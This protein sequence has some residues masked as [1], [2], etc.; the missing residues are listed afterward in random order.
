MR[1]AV[2]SINQ[3]THFIQ[4]HY[5]DYGLDKPLVIGEFRE[6]EAAGLKITDLYN[7]AYYYGYSGA[8]GWHAI[9]NNWGNIRT[10]IEWL[11]GRNDQQKGGLVNFRV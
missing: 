2:I 5:T 7:Y 8:W 3:N 6:S 10:G 9:E 4:K 11:R 1:F